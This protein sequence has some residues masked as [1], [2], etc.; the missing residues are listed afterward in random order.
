MN[1]SEVNGTFQILIRKCTNKVS[2]SIAV[3]RRSIVQAANPWGA[4]GYNI[5]FMQF[6]PLVIYLYT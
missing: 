2:R 6:H 4:V 3:S 1:G 5:I